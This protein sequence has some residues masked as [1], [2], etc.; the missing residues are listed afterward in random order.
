VDPKV[1]ATACR[2]ECQVSLS[3]GVAL[4]NACSVA[5]CLVA[6]LRPRSPSQNPFM[7]ADVIL[8]QGRV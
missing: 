4:T 5:D 2:Q 3:G 6:M 7:P 1:L 8:L